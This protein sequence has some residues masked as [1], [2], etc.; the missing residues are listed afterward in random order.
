MGL[1][2]RVF[3]L[4]VRSD[5]AAEDVPEPLVLELRVIHH[6]ADLWFILSDLLASHPPQPATDNLLAVH[7][8]AKLS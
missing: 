6:R 7:T 2:K 8:A 3:D 4:D 5:L 1:V